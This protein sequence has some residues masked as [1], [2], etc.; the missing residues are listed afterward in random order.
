MTTTGPPPATGAW[1]EGD[2]AG[3]RLFADLGDLALESG[4]VLPDVRIAYETW[5]EPSADGSNAVLVLHAL[6]GDSH[7]TGDAGPGHPSPGWWSGLVGPGRPIDTDRF[8]VVAPNILGGCQGSTGP[9]SPGPDGRPW[10]A[11][12]PALTVRDQVAAEQLLADRL[13]VARWAGVTGGSAGGMRALEWAISRPE[14]VAT[15]FLL[16][17]SASASADQIG[18]S[19]TQVEAI[20]SDPAFAGG[21]YYDAAPGDGPH[22]GLELA[23][24][25]AHLSYR[26]AGELAERFG[27]TVGEDGRWAVES[28]LAHHGDKLARRFDANTYVTLTRAMDS[29]DVGRDRG[30]VPAA[31]GRITARTVVA[32]IDSD[33]LYPLSQQEEIA[34]SVPT[35]DYLDVVESVHG[36]DGFLVELDA[37]APLARRL[38][39]T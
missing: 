31:L 4:E 13:G 32:G 6:T 9:S 16:A 5:G 28:Y 19:T 30:G 18:L 10:G 22:R 38:L 14:S 36:H 29:H 37:V 11:R 7:V 25:I 24:R 8:F 27:R 1:R 20:V 12:F 34:A 39:G 26:S 15:L 21:D 35:C 17:A 23:R 2:A 33:R 3:G